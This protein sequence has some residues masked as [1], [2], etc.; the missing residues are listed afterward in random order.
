MESLLM[1]LSLHKGKEALSFARYVNCLDEI[2]EA[3]G[4]GV[5]WTTVSY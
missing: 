3:R 5:D 2:S 1:F 4:R